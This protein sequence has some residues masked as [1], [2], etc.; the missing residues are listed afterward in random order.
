MRRLQHCNIYDVFLARGTAPAGALCVRRCCSTRREGAEAT[1]LE[2]EQLM[3]Y[4]KEHHI[5]ESEALLKEQFGPHAKL[6]VHQLAHRPLNFPSREDE[7]ATNKEEISEAQRCP[8]PATSGELSRNELST[9]SPPHYY[10]AS[11]TFRL[12]GFPVE[13]ASAKGPHVEATIEKCVRQALS[14]DVEF[15]YSRGTQERSQGRGKKSTNTR[16][17][18]QSYN[19]NSSSALRPHQ[20][21]LKVIMDELR[22]LCIHF[23]RTIKF[24]IKAPQASAL[25]QQQREPTT[26]NSHHH[27]HH[28]PISAGGVKAAGAE[29]M[30]LPETDEDMRALLT[31]ASKVLART[32]DGAVTDFVLFRDCVDHTVAEVM[33]AMFTSLKGTDKSEHLLIVAQE[34]LHA[35]VLLVPSVFGFT[36]SDLVKANFDEMPLSREFLYVLRKDGQ[37]V[38]VVTAV[39]PSKVYVPL[40]YL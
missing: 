23:S 35:Q 40:H 14:S 3:P 17:R 29:L 13:V 27:L 10:K 39:T 16:S 32:Q 18:N 11:A 38:S 2:A 20:L 6:V 15:I 5:A 37:A 12:L 21:E 26:T 34:L 33:Y 22:Q 1:S 7:Q 28:T 8:V 9:S 31:P 24:S 30:H 4:N 36:D 19:T 25:H